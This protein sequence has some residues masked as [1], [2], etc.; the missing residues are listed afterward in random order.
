[1]RLAGHP[2][3]A[4][5]TRM[6]PDRVAPAS[7][8]RGGRR[9]RLGPAR[10]PPEIHASRLV[11]TASRSNPGIRVIRKSADNA[12]RR[13]VIGERSVRDRVAVS[14]RVGAGTSILRGRIDHHGAVA[15]ADM[16]NGRRRLTSW[17][18]D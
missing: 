17:P 14:P 18:R 16:P 1:L 3:I 13:S 9:P 12:G 2:R 8:V 5:I 4:Q 6:M 7:P 11:E 15:Q 10:Q